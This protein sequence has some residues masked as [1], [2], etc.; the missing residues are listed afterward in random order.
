LADAFPNAPD[1]SKAGK[2][3]I[4]EI[5]LIDTLT[6]ELYEN[7][8]RSRRIRTAD[9]SKANYQTIIDW[10]KDRYADASDF[11]FVLTGN[12]EAEK[13]KELIAK[14]WGALPSIKRTEDFLPINV[15]YRSGLRKN[16]FKRK[17]EDGKC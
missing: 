1:L 10:L 2:E 5:A 16:A 14:Y 4:P 15:N 13:S 8:A 9:L 6:K 3:N 17:M 11:T 12:I 7:I